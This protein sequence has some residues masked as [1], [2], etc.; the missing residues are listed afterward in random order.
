MQIV[1]GKITGNV[2]KTHTDYLGQWTATHLNGKNNKRILI[3]NYYQSINHKTIAQAGTVTVWT[4]QYVALQETHHKPDPIKQSHKDLQ[5]F[6]QTNT[7]TEDSIILVGD[8]NNQLGVGHSGIH[9][10]I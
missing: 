5:T 1:A 2:S 10:I 8:F 9:G 4:Q 6:I 3:I 7:K